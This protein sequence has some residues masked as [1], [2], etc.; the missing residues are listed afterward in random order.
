M[1]R[2]YTLS[3]G[4]QTVVNAVVTLASIR[5]G[6]TC[7]IEILRAWVSQSANATSN[8]QRVQ[9]VRQAAALPTVVSQTPRPAKEGDPVSQIV[10]GT[11]LAA[12]TCGINASAEGAGAKTPIID[13]AFNVLNGWLWVAT[14]AETIILSPGSANVFSLFFPVAALSLSNWAFGLTY[15]ELG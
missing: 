13:D 5:P 8:Q 12:G 14:P 1:S 4:G 15:R 10:G 9:L 11:A 3:A 2:E 7:A 6:T